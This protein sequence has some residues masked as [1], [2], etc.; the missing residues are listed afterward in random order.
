MVPDKHPQNLTN[1]ILY[2]WASHTRYISCY[3]YS[4]W[5]ALQCM[6][7]GAGCSAS[8]GVCGFL[9]ILGYIMTVSASA[10][11]LRYAEGATLLAIVTVGFH[12]LWKWSIKLFSGV[13]VPVEI[14]I[15]LCWLMNQSLN[16]TN[17]KLMSVYLTAVESKVPLMF[18]NVSP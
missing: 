5:F 18:L 10:L 17:W 6:F 2:V 1:N 3:Q 7:G 13:L 8:P 14:I 15:G 11:L 4:W 9:F 16:F 12:S